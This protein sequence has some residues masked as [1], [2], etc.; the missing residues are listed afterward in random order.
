M[1]AKH[2][3]KETIL[4]IGLYERNFPIFVPGDT[5]EVITKVKEIV[6]ATKDKA[7]KNQKRNQSFTGTVLAIKGTGISKT[8]SIRSISEGIAI[9][10]TFP[11]YASSVLEI[12]ILSKGAVRRAKLYYLRDRYGK[13]SEVKKKKITTLIPANNAAKASLESNMTAPATMQQ[14]TSHNGVN[15][16]SSL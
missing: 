10:R 6:S 4:N 2:Y 9:E 16:N 7:S 1:K 13:K 11:Y 15:V 12:K 3:T 5:I 14:A 8:F